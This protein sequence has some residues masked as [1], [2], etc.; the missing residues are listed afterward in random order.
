M[1]AGRRVSRL[2]PIFMG[3]Y[4][5]ELALTFPIKGEG[6]LESLPADQY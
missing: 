3:E 4:P 5:Q 2:C 6:I 1:S